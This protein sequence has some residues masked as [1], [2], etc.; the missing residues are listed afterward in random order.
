LYEF[1]VFITSFFE[2]F[3]MFKV[4]VRRWRVVTDKMA[5]VDGRSSFYV[6]NELMPAYFGLDIGTSSLKLAHVEGKKVHSLGLANNTQAK[7]VMEMNNA[8]KIALVELVKHLVKDSGVKPH[9]VVASIAEPLVFSRVMKFPVMSSPELATAI[10][11]EL[12]Q[13]VPFPPAEIEV[14]WVIMQ[15]PQRATGEEQISV[16]VVAT[17][18]KVSETYTNILELA[19][20]EPIRLENEI[21]ALSRAFAP[22]LTDQSPGLVMNMGASGTTMI[23]GGREIIYNNY[24]V[25]VGG[26]ALTKFIADSFNLPLDQAES[27]KRTYGIAKDQLEGRLYS[28][29]KPIIDNIVGEAKKLIVSFQNDNKGT[30]V[31][32]IVITGGGSYLNGILP[33]MTESFPNTEVIIGDVFTG[34]SVPEKYRGLGP[35]F[36]LA[37]GL[38]S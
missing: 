10:K 35:V 29:L 9:Q 24:Y 11:W 31:G 30:T 12:D 3:Y 6:Y 22:S 36:D 38:S 23:V 27:Y 21:P 20:L 19:G 4:L 14:S 2:G 25:P 15:K 7:N 34:M 17:P 16:Y 8:E 5:R 13:T 32:R 28:V 1:A 37:C 18:N 26:N 33:Y